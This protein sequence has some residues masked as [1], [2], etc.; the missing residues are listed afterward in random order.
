LPLEPNV[1]VIVTE[2]RNTTYRQ[3]AWYRYASGFARGKPIVVVEN[4]YG[5][6]V[7]DLVKD[8][9][10]GRGYDL[11]R[12][13]IYEAAALGANMSLPYGAW[14]GSVEKDSFWPPHEL[15]TEIGE[16]L[17]AHESLFGDASAARSAVVFSAES[18]FLL[19]SRDR[20]LANNTLN[21]MSEDIIPFWNVC[22]PL[23]DGLQ[24]YDIV[25]FPD[26]E[27]R[28]DDISVD[29]L[30]S[31]STVVLP[32]CHVLTLE[33]VKVLLG[34]LESGGHIVRIGPVGTNLVGEMGSAIE[35]HPRTRS[36][37][38]PA[39]IEELVGVPQ[40]R[41]S[42]PVSAAVNLQQV[43]GGVAV[44]LIRYDFDAE[45]DRV[46][47]LDTLTLDIELDDEFGTVASFGALRPPQ[48]EF[49]REDHVYKLELRDVPL[50]SILLLQRL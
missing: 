28:P 39:A 9:G 5:G 31:Y 35:S 47:P 1:D 34:Y 32:H 38:L 2:M 7:P 42:A 6:V 8:L 4:P 43:A 23:S 19:E 15:C 10:R 22:R 20:T 14:M 46:D 48:V 3:P 41:A 21:L 26:G 36:V 16:W 24:P 37:N 25:I 18:N 45:L 11:F 44:H 27:L 12:M 29:D 40:V 33:Q 17:A 49:Q 30:S 50:Y 13:S